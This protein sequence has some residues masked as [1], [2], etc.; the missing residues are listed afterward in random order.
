MNLHFFVS[1]SRKPNAKNIVQ[2]M[3][4]LLLTT[5]FPDIA[6]SQFGKAGFVIAI[7]KPQIQQQEPHNEFI[8]LKPGEK[9]KFRVKAISTHNVELDSIE[10]SADG[11]KPK[12]KFCP[13]FDLLPCHQLDHSVEYK[14]DE[15]RNTPYKVTAKV[16]AKNGASTTI[17]WRVTVS[18]NQIQITKSEPQVHR[19]QLNV[20][21]SQRFYI[22]AK[23]DD[24]IQK[25]EY[26]R[27]DNPQKVDSNRCFI[28]CKEASHSVKWRFAQAGQYT[29]K[30]TIKS[31]KGATVQQTWTVKV[32][33]LQP[34]GAPTKTSGS[35]SP[36]TTIL[37]NNY[38]NPFNPETWI[39]YHLATNTDVKIHIYNSRG[40]LVRALTLGHQPAGYYTSRSRAAHWD[41]CNALGERVAS[42]IYFYQLLTDEISPMRK[43]I[44]LK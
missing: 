42:G 3:I 16:V 13:F 4:L 1:R 34:R 31:K 25:L 9:Q 37:L 44:I 17:V 29:V 20:G 8:T 24:G 33:D 27:S 32:K 30:V 21:Q 40:T 10:I 6:S 23:C 18:P 22:K 35:S 28:F 15:P 26:S 41:G 7:G 12:N 14:W 38:P 36:D 43:M 11:Q 5:I 39:P 2:L 19:I